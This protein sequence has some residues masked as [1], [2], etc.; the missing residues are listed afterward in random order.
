MFHVTHRTPEPWETNA[1]APFLTI[2]GARGTVAVFA[3]GDDRFVIEAP[4]QMQVVVGF[5]SARDRARALAG[6]GT[7]PSHPRYSRPRAFSSRLE[8]AIVDP[9]R[10]G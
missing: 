4:E 3:L 1:A 8:H 5:T 10:R 6:D 7:R 2:E 9:L